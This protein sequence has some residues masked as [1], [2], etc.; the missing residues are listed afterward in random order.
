MLTGEELLA[1]GR[2]YGYDGEQLTKW[3]IQ[4]EQEERQEEKEERKKQKD[5]EREIRKYE[6]ENQ[7]KRVENEE[8]LKKEE[9][10]LE[11][12]RV[13]LRT[14]ELRQ[15]TKGSTDVTATL[16]IV[17]V[18]Q[19]RSK[20]T[21]P[22]FDGD[23]D[24]LDFFLLRFEEEAKQHK[25]QP[26]TWTNELRKLMPADLLPVCFMGNKSGT[27]ATYEEVK[28]ALSRHFNLTAQ[29]YR[30]KFYA[31]TPE[32]NE[33]VIAYS[34]R[35]KHYITRWA[36]LARIEKTFDALRD[37]MIVDKLLHTINT[38][39]VNFVTERNDMSLDTVLDQADNYLI[40]HPDKS[41]TRPKV[42][43]PPILNRTNSGDTKPGVPSCN[44][45]SRRGHVTEECYLLRETRPSA[46]TT[47]QETPAANTT[48]GPSA[49]YSG[50]NQG[51]RYRDFATFAN[52]LR[53]NNRQVSQ[54][55]SNGARYFHN[56]SQQ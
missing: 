14:L 48:N 31:L 49:D 6:R 28:T 37:L 23:G 43:Q 8:L 32:P 4:R 13:E 15:A 33:S 36:D 26:D 20:V 42:A 52:T 11:R 9:I 22:K 21:L 17:S 19:G 47:G 39:V 16:D 25:W 44:F 51:R 40:A 29:G 41:L 34:N 30:H 55:Q 3:V 56:Q 35:A 12:A 54:G 5:E 24:H 53:G 7:K 1:E 45:C 10:S 27:S 2:S 18:L 46:Q 50:H 38:D